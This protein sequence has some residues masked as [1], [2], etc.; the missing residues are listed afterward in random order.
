VSFFFV[1]FVLVAAAIGFKVFAVMLNRGS[2]DSWRGQDETK[3][4]WLGKI[5]PAVLLALL[6]LFV[7]A[8]SV[9]VV[10]NG[11][12]IVT[13]TFGKTEDSSFEPGVH[14]IA[15]W[16]NTKAYDTLR[17]EFTYEGEV[18]TQ[19]SN[20]LEV[21]V[22]FATKLDP[23]SAWKIQ[24]LIGEDYFDRVV[25]PA[26][27]TATRSGIAKFG[28]EKAAT[29]ERSEVEAA[30]QQ[31]FEKI[32]VDQLVAA[33]FGREDAKHVLHVF[34]VQ[35]RKSLPDKK[36]LNSVAEKSASKQ[37]LDRQ[38]TLTEIAAEGRTRARAS[39]TSSRAFP[40]ASP[41]TKSRR[42]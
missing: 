37:D 36:V 19:D 4:L 33:G 25:V 28:W 13:K 23:A 35:L 38:K 26:G 22:G 31:D 11:E 6:V 17:R 24:T 21:S 1:S 7:F 8:R 5:V 20:P 29:S 14:L 39:R 12:V 18:I 27:Q 34:P 32:V 15:P 2:K 9:K 10:D 42:F 3:A 30:I 40:R 41:P 16:V